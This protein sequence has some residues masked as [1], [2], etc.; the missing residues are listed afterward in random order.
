M[1]T[2]FCRGGGG[3]IAAALLALAL[4]FSS[5]SRAFAADLTA[6]S[7]N[8]LNVT[9][10]AVSILAQT[11]GGAGGAPAAEPSAVTPPPPGTT[12][13]SGWLSGF[14]VSGFASQQFGMWEN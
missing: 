13:E 7:A 12:Q 5:G 10:A 1:G 14:H 9:G 3:V 4:V 2:S 8:G 11:G 6:T